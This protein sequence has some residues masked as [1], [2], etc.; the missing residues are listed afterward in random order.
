MTRLAAVA[1][2]R[3]LTARA[4]VCTRWAAAKGDL[5][6]RTP[7]DAGAVWLHSLVDHYDDD[8]DRRD[9]AVPKCRPV[10]TGQPLSRSQNY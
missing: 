7:H 2:T 1:V 4:V 8:D 6:G 5:G 9:E 3:R 10:M